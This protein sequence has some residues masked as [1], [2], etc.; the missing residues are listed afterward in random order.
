MASSSISHA[1][2]YLFVSKCELGQLGVDLHKLL[3]GEGLGLPWAQLGKA[4]DCRG[5]RQG[6]RCQH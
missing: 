6:S 5:S 1:V 3:S 2:A 4:T